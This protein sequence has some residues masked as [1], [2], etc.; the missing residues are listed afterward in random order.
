MA[1]KV[2]TPQT[3]L[4]LLCGPPAV[5]KSEL[6]EQL[7]T[8]CGDEGDIGFIIVTYDVFYPK[9][10]RGSGHREKCSSIDCDVN[11]SEFSSKRVRSHL[12]TC[13]ERFIITNKLNARQHKDYPEKI[14]SEDEWKRFCRCVSVSEGV[15]LSENGRYAVDSVENSILFTI[16]PHAAHPPTTHWHSFNIQNNVAITSH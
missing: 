6:A 8:R 11:T 9:D 16:L 4:L 12:N 7:R 1:A 15:R 5:G 10:E 3:L 2:C 14:P 13:L